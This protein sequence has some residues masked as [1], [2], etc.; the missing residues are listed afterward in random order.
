MAVSIAIFDLHLAAESVIVQSLGALPPAALLHAVLHGDA[1]AA[2][3]IA[4]DPDLAGDDDPAR[5]SVHALLWLQ[6]ASFAL[7]EAG[8][9]RAFQQ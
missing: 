4:D 1:V 2:K 7:R 5:R 3:R 6:R 9:D 8:N